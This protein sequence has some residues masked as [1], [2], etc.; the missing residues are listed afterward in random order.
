MDSIPYSEV[1]AH[2]AETLK[3]LEVREE[4]IF[5]S[6]RGEPAGVL[7]SVAQYQRLAGPVAKDFWSAVCAWRAENAD[8]LATPEAPE[9]PF[10]DLRDPT[11][12]G[13][14]SPVDFGAA[15]VDGGGHPLAR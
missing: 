10:A 9:D 8:Y 2:L 3:K 12:T 11:T 15:D 6:R 13:G 4:P 5:I 7:M 14:R 1:R